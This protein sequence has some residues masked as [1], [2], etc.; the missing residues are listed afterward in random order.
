V[1]RYRSAS[2]SLI[3]SQ[4]ARIALLAVG[5]GAPS[6]Q[7]VPPDV[8]RARVAELLDHQQ[9]C[10]HNDVAA[11]LPG[12]IGDLHAKGRPPL[13][14]T[15]FADSREDASRAMYRAIEHAGTPPSS[16]C[17]HS[18]QISRDRLVAGAD[19]VR[20][21]RRA[22]LE[23]MYAGP[24]R[25]DQLPEQRVLAEPPMDG[26]HAPGRRRDAQRYGRDPG[27]GKVPERRYER[28]A[29]AMADELAYHVEIVRAVDD[30]RLEARRG[31]HPVQQR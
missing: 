5:M 13:S 3:S 14:C 12:L 30:S 16:P 20:A 21:D 29:E 11:L 2:D 7:Q 31:A 24:Q 8:L 6:G 1:R 19:A 10:R 26:V 23:L 9:A 17:P 15:G 18:A 22:V 28:D 4:L 25:R 27:S